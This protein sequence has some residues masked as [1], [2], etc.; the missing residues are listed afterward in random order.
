MA[1]HH[2]SSQVVQTPQL[3]MRMGH[4]DMSKWDIGRHYFRLTKPTISMLV[5]L[6][7]L[8]AYLVPQ[9]VYPPVMEM[10]G[11]LLGVAL[12]SASAA[13]FNQLLEWQTDR[14]MKRTQSRSL[15]MGYI[16]RTEASWFGGLLGVLGIGVLL[17]F[18][19][20]L[21]AIIG[22][23]GH[24]FYV[25]LYTLVLKKRTVQNI[26][27]GGAAGA[28]GPL[29]G[30]AAA[31]SLATPFPW[32][33]FMLIFLWTPP[34]FWSL[35]LKYQGDYAAAG[36]PMYPVIYGEDRTRKMIF[37]YSLS[38]IPV[39]L[40]LAITGLWIATIVSILITGFFVYLCGDLYRNKKRSHQDLMKIFRWSC[41]YALL[42]FFILSL[43][44]SVWLWLAA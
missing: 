33:L 11:L 16:S 36:I 27:I 18:A 14:T 40:M 7:A 24:L 29:M 26:V 21:T 31:G 43:E 30:A 10:V 2:Q 4:G 37:M 20:Q 6:S 8:P 19:G 23:C 22:L 28:V 42:I 12:M 44:K 41:Y 25:I 5:T 1:V 9:Q 32:I 39:V 35:S 15:P 3:A 13:V 38:L 17:G 34:H